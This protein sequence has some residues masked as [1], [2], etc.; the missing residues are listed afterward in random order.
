MGNLCQKVNNPSPRQ[1]GGSTGVSTGDV[2]VELEGPLSKAEYNERVVSCPM[3]RLKLKSVTMS[4]SYFS[5]RGYYP[6]DL[7]KA[8]QDS[9]FV[10]APFDGDEDFGFFAVLDGHG[11]KGHLCAQFARDAVQVSLL[12]ESFLCP[13]FVD[14]NFCPGKSEA[15]VE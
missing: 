10:N 15:I 14:R 11:A 7:S 9:Y 4:Y 13:L 3:T 1:Q 8:N 12:I 2:D 6:D 5:Q